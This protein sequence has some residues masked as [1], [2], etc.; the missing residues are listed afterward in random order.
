MINPVNSEIRD[1]STDELTVVSGG[2]LIRMIAFGAEYGLSN[3]LTN[4]SGDGKAFN[5]Q[6]KGIV[7]L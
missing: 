2:D 4:G 3:W 7:G 1:L 6:F 5:Q